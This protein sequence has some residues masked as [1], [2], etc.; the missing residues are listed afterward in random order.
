MSKVILATTSPY[1]KEVFAYIGIPFVTEKSNVDESRVKRESPEKL[2]RA[3]S[4]LKAEAVAKNHRDAIVIGMDSV[5]CFNHQIL[6]KPK[7]REEAFQRL[8]SL[9]LKNFQFYTGVFVIDIAFK[10]R[11]SRIV[12]TEIFMRNLSDEE[13]KRYL[14][15]D[16][17]IYNYA[18]GYDPLKYLSSTFVKR[19]EGSYNNFTRGIPLEEIIE[20]LY[21]LREDLSEFI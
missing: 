9:S 20:I 1:R 11:I 19:I 21:E 13:I 2:V 16:P 7:S 5:G 12:K 4:Q 17:E 15:E 14:N 18:L 6:E 8:R 3:L 10:K